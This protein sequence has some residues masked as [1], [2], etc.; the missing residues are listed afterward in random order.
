MRLD[1]PAFREFLMRRGWKVPYL[2]DF[3]T[4]PEAT[5]ELQPGGP[6]AVLYLE[7]GTDDEG[8]VT[9]GE[10]GFESV[11]GRHLDARKLPPAL[12]SEA[13]RD[14]LGAVKAAT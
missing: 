12:V 4:T 2:G 8:R 5:R 1:Q 13:A 3:F 14:V 7:P 6:A 11:Q 10:L 9:L